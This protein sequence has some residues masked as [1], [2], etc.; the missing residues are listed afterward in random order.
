MTQPAVIR[1]DYCHAH[2]HTH[3]HAAVWRALTDPELH[4]R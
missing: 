1:V 4:A 3:A 2:A